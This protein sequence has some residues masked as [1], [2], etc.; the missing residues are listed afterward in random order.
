M[1]AMD[2]AL[3]SVCFSASGVL[4]SG[5]GAPERTDAQAYASDVGSWSGNELSLRD[6]VLENLPRDDTKIEG[7]A[8]RGQLDQFG[9]GAE[10]NNKFMAGSAL[11]LRAELFHG[12][13]HGAAR[14]DLKFGSL[15][16][17]ERRQ[18]KGQT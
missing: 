16:I 10:A 11:E 3:S 17:G 1:E 6:G 8:G 2:R 14:Q 15:H 4:I 13:R 5:L 9:G 18:H 7:P 12:G